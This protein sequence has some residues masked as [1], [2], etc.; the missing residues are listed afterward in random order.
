MRSGINGLRRLSLRIVLLLAPLAAAPGGQAAAEQSFDHGL[1]WRVEVAGVAPSYVFGTFHLSD[2]RIGDAAA[3]AA[4]ALADSRSLTVEVLSDAQLR[5]EYA[6]RIALPDGRTLDMI[7]GP[8]LFQRV[9]DLAREY[10]YGPGVLKRIKP[11]AVIA[12]L[13]SPPREEVRRTRGEHHLDAILERLARRNGIAVHALE[14]PEEQLSLF[15][16]MSEA[17]Q[18]AMVEDRVANDAEFRSNFETMVSLYTQADIGGLYRRGAEQLAAQGETLMQ[19]FLIDRNYRMVERMEPRLREGAA[20]I[21]I[22]ALHLGGEQ[23]VLNLL[24]QKG[25]KLERAD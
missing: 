23:G 24:S 3:A 20:L 1:L 16:D 8:P 6:R 15:A 12:M 19:R 14:T 13:S 5:A 11:W 18:V 9:T 10:G 2:P 7:L 17:D 22:G 25:Y 21:A 4:R